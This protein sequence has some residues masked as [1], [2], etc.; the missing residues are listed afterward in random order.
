MTGKKKQNFGVGLD[1][2]T[3]NIVSARTVG[4]GIDTKRMRDAFL[5]LPKSK[6]RMLKMSDTS[7]VERDDDVLILG[8]AA[9]ELA[10]VFGGDP[11]RPLAGGLISSRES[12]ALGVLKLLVESVLGEPVTENEVCYFSVP[13][14]PLDQPDKDIIYHQG[15]FERIVEECGYDPYPANEAMAIIFAEC[16][17]EGFSGLAFSFGCLTPD[18]RIFTRDGYVPV[19]AVKEGDEVLTRTGE[20]GRVVKTWSRPHEGDVYRIHFEGNPLGVALTGNHQ[21][22]ARRGSNHRG[23]DGDWEWIRAE[24]LNEGDIVGEPV[25]AGTGRRTSLCL[26]EKEKNGPETK[27]VIDWSMKMGRFLGYFLADGHLGPDDRNNIFID[28]GPNEQRYVDDLRG[29]VDGLLQRSLTVTAHGNAHRCQFSHKSL[30]SWLRD[31]CYN[32]GVKRFP[33]KIEDIRQ[34]LAEGLL[35]GLIRG[36]GWSSQNLHFGNS[37]ESLITACHLL[38]GRLGLTSTVTCREPRDAEFQGGRIIKAENCKPE[39][40]VHLSGIDAAFFRN[41]IDEG[42]HDRRAPRVWREGGFRCTRIR[43]VEVEPYEGTVHDLTIEGDPSFCAPYITLHNSGMTNVALALNTTEVLSF[44]VQ[45]GG[46][47]IDKHSAQAVGMTQAQMCALKEAGIDLMQHPTQPEE[48]LA[49][50][51]KAMIEFAIDQV[52]A[53]FE[54]RMGQRTLPKAIPIIVSGGTSQAKGFLDFFNNVWRKK[55]RKF[56]IEIS[57]VRAAKDPLNAVALGMLVQAMQEYE[58]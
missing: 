39:W 49:L 6:T 31:H 7:Y 47:W 19:A 37:S 42:L 14:A 11:R 24:N 8:D 50:Y 33:L 58:D 57:E 18:T 13:A 1:I 17:A 26:K 23:S 30:C 2:G 43:K 54:T 36:D 29:L 21:V 41:L 38:F 55:K 4:G 51:Y 10:N 56:P 53:H 48:A 25:V 12:D 22:W 20:Y 28:F 5:S 45:R 15:V 34:G 40:T 35:V 46:D 44:S 3:M 52:A 9:M 16:A 27:R 32:A